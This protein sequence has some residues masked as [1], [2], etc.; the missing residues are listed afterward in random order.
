MTMTAGAGHERPPPLHAPVPLSPTRHPISPLRQMRATSPSLSLAEPDLRSAGNGDVSYTK[1]LGH[2]KARSVAGDRTAR[3]SLGTGN[4][5][6]AAAVP[7]PPFPP[8]KGPA[9]GRNDMVEKKVFEDGPKRT[10]SVWREFVA[11]NASE[12]GDGEGEGRSEVD[13]HAGRRRRVEST[14]HAGSVKGKGHRRKE[15]ADFT[16]VCTPEISFIKIGR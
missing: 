7:L 15:S 1:G 6:P 16:E 12:I 11:K 9:A 4:Q 3:R 13:S 2:G 8:G 10:I 14:V 5:P